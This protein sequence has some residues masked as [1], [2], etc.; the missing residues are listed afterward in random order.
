MNMWDTR[1]GNEFADRVPKDLHR[2][3]D[4]LETLHTDQQALLEVCKT[5]ALALQ[6]QNDAIAGLA[7][8]IRY[9]RK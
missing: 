8:E 4:S 3:S 2:I 5:L 6:E 7:E 9:L 1:R